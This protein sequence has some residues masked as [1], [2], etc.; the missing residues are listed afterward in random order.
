VPIAFADFNAFGA[1]AANVAE[2]GRILPEGMVPDGFAIPFHFY[3]EFM[4]YNG[5]YDRARDMMALI[6]R[7]FRTLY[8]I[9]PTNLD[10][11]MDIEF[12][13]TAEGRLRIKQARRW[14]E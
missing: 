13:I 4:K 7:R 5:F 9:R 12:K 14:V 11:A 10:F 3:D 6:Q 2:L 1:R 8:R